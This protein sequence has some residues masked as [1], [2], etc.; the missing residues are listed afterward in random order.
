M[1]ELQAAKDETLAYKN[2]TV[3]INKDLE[4]LAKDLN[5]TTSAHK[6]LVLRHD[7]TRSELEMARDDFNKLREEKRGWQEQFDVMHH[8]VVRA[9]RRIRCLDHLTNAR[10]EARQDDVF[11]LPLRT[12]KMAALSPD[13]SAEVLKAILS[14]NA[15]IQ[16]LAKFFVENHL[17]RAVFCPTQRQSSHVVKAKTMLGDDL[18]QMLQAQSEMKALTS[19]QLLMTVV[20]EVFLVHWCSSIIEGWYPERPSFSDLLVELA[21]QSAGITS[22]TSPSELFLDIYHPSFFIA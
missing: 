13:P 7:R 17:E 21:L 2:S 22:S 6:S 20:F 4:R 16:Q 3:Q 10:F 5:A 8:K 19:Y 1:R 9:E 11:G 18:T 12:K 15:E 14:L